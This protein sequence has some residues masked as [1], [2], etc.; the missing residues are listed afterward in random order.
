MTDVVVMGAAIIDRGRVLV[1]RRTR[2][3]EH[4]G[5]WELPGGKVEPGED[6]GDAVVRE[7]DEELGCTVEVTGE[8]DGAVP[9]RS[10]YV[11]RVATARLVAG[12]PV[13]QEHDAV[14]WLAADELGDVD[15]LPADRPFLPQLRQAL[16]EAGAQ[17]HH[18]HFQAHFHAAE[19]AADAAARLRRDGF[20]AEAHQERFAGEDDDEDHPWMVRTDAPEIV[21]ELLVEEHDGWLDPAAEGAPSTAQSAAPSAAH[22][23]PPPEL[24]TG[25]RRIKGHFRKG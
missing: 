1:A 11:L 10:G 16:A 15:W 21:V 4:A 24:P 12:A 13:P 5:G 7:I 23:V 18:A 14:R 19:Q 2:P 8:L 3:P 6:P 25:P 9:I 17:L 22:V 20:F